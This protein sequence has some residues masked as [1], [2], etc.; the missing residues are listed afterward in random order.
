MLGKFKSL[1]AKDAVELS[2]DS[3]PSA[4]S[5]L[6][7]VP[8]KEKLAASKLSLD[9]EAKKLVSFLEELSIKRAGDN[10][11]NVLKERFCGRGIKLLSALPE[12]YDEL[13]SAVQLSAQE[14]SS[15]SL[16]E[17]RHFHAF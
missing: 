11:V 15:I 5:E 14:I 7:S 9:K 6:D 3:V 2:L 12:P 8:E 1:F 13:I 16:K 17:F 4:L 10:Y